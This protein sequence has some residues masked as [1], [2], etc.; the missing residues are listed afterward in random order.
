MYQGACEVH[1]QLHNHDLQDVHTRRYS[2]APR[3]RPHVSGAG[4]SYDLIG[5]G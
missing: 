3:D 1:E 2:T 5:R 4:R